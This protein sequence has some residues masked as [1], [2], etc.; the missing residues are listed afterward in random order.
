MASSLAAQLAQISANSRTSLNAK[1][2]KAAHSKSLIFEPQ[3]AAGQ[4]YAEIYTICH[5]GFEELCHLDKRFSDLFAK[6]LFSEQSQEADRTKM[7]GEENAALDKQVDFFLHQ[8]GSR[9]RLMPAIK[10]VEWLIRRFRIHEFN[11]AT[12][13]TTFLPYHTMPAFVTLLSILPPK[14]SAEYK[15]LDPYI[16]SLTAPP[17]AAI[18]QQATNS[19]ELL[20]TISQYTLASCREHQ[21]YPALIS[22]WAGVMAEV[23]NGMLDKLRSGRQAIQLENTQTL[24]Q[25]VGPT[26]GEAMVMKSIPGIQ[27]AS[28]MIVT[29]LAAKGSLDD[30]SL[31]AFMEQL[32][33]GLTTETFQPGLVTLCIIAQQRSAKQVSA[34]VAK[35]LIKVQTLVPTLLQIS[36][37]HRI[38]KL[39]NGLALAFVDRLMK[40][41]DVRSLPLIKG[42]LLANVLQEK[43][44]K[45]IY[46]ALLLAAHKIDDEVDK[47][48][49]IR[50][51][52]GSALVSLA[53][54]GGEVGD[55]V[56][57]AI[58]EVDYNIDELELNLRIGSATIRPTQVIEQGSEDEMEVK[59]IEAPNAQPNLDSALEALSKLKLT[60]SSCLSQESDSLFNDLCTVFFSAAVSETDLEKFDATPLLSRPLAP[61]NSFYFSF[62][63][64]IWCGAYPTLA[65]VAAL[66]RAKARLKD[67]DCAGKDFQA[68]AVYAAV[69]LSD[70]AKKVRRAA[71]DLLAVLNNLY[72]TP[73]PTAWGSEDLYG[74]T[75]APN[76]MGNDAAKSLVQQ[77]LVPCLEEAVLHEDHVVA[78]TVSGLEGSKS[79]T[80][81]DK[82]HISSSSRLSI[83]Q[84]ISGQVTATPLL[85]VRLRLLRSINQIKSI[86]GTSRTDLLLPLL[87]SWA[88][89]TAADAAAQVKGESLDENTVN[90][91]VVDV[92]V[93]NH[94]AGLEVLFQL[95]KDQNTRPSLV[96]AIFG[97]LVKLWPS[98][99]SNTKSET[100]EVMLALS[101][102][103][104]DSSEENT[105]AVEAVDLLRKVE[106]TT[107]ILLDFVNSLQFD[108]KLASEPPATKRRRV[109]MAEQSKAVGVPT[110]PDVRAA[111]NK[112][113]FVLELVQESMPEN[114][115]ELLP[116]LFTTLSDL[117][118]LSR[119]VG[120]EL[121]YL[122]NLVLSSLLAMIPAYKDNKELA[123]DASV[124]HG[125]VLAACIQKSTSPTVINAAL[126]LVASLARTAPDVVLQS[127]MPIFTYMG[128]SVLKQGDD[129]S[130]HVVNQ[131][132]KEVIPPLIETFRKKGRNLVASTKDLLA[133]FV[134]A[135]EHIPPHRKLDLFTSLIE[136]LG[137]DDFLFAVLA[138]FVD[139]YGAT[140][141]IISFTAEIMSHFSVEIQLS[142]LVKLIGLVG[143]VYKPKPALANTLIGNDANADQDKT[144]AKQLTLLP[145]LLANRRLKRE[146]T[147]LAERDDMESGKIRD[148]YANLLEGILN[149]AATVKGKKVLYSRCGDALSNL[150]NL[151]SI[152]E[153]IKS[154]ETLLDRPNVGLRQK[155]LRALELRVDSENTGDKQSRDAL[156]AFLPQL[157]AVIRESDDMNYKHTAVTCVDKISE[158]YGKKDLD[159][160]AAAAETI[161]GDHCLGQSSQT[162]RVMALLCLASLVDVLQDGIVPVLPVAI[163]KALSYLEDSLK[164]ETANVELHDAAYAFLAALAQH[165]PYMISGAYLDRL[166]ACS[167]TSAATELNAESNSNRLH[168]LQFLAKLVDAKTMYLALEKNWLHATNAGFSAISEYL[169]ILGMALDKHTKAVVSKN[170][171]TLSTI[172][173]NTMDLRRNMAIGECKAAL[174]D[175]EL[176]QIETMVGE[177]ALKMIYKLNDAA[178]RPVFSELTEWSFSGLP[179]ND[180]AGKTLRLLSVYGFF[181]T[182]FD[183]L[184]S[185]VTSYASYIVEMSAN[186]VSNTNLKDANEMEL[187]K[188][189]LKT[190]TKCFEHDQDGFWQAPGHFGVVAPVLIAQ[191]GHAASIEA[192]EE[193]LIPAVVEL[194][195]AADSQEHHKELN[196]TLLKH[197]RSE[198][199]A[200]RLAV[201]KCQQALTE[202]LDDEWLR[203][204]PEMLPYISELQDDDDEV[205]ERENRRWIVGI[206]GK[207]GES[208]DS[209]L[210]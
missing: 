158:K 193:V 1:A 210:Q 68:I 7:T 120:S 133:S 102:A 168:C 104:T 186:V 182:F 73:C 128:S 134:T 36:T 132:V 164:G 15:F 27:I 166:L 90:Q 58:Q 131:T 177:D 117:H 5:E 101:Q 50:N 45:V 194:A 188:R 180:V 201:V 56:R 160:V 26:L 18:V 135:Y 143:D 41:G 77:I 127:V 121:G 202:K 162:L 52:L 159:A 169:R 39:A 129:Y 189:V 49:H 60:T 92:V 76:K 114:H 63:M 46:K 106:L 20:S 130:A 28:Y 24:L 123:I 67:S 154:V 187:W 110:G 13:I 65:K 147:Q 87:Q 142:T 66:E 81:K 197:L 178:F 153:F 118:H 155:V 152:A 98:M 198:Q 161:A 42:L 139:R 84:F 8:V 173:I 33:V 16:R 125:D 3:V 64:R 105:V 23:V 40:K 119:Q 9:L 206:E 80:K 47:D 71:A 11:T 107:D 2:L 22:F 6:S 144:S 91:A 21:E 170:V 44:A 78:A 113:T 31:N 200:V 185:I 25:R 149:L 195:V 204:L 136:N 69:A 43:Q 181:H 103:A 112:T 208:L 62:Y 122:Q 146:I 72:D 174:A 79:S 179:K 175:D 93:A 108:V 190:L 115:P 19:H 196:G 75:V 209:M 89:L 96:Q 163:P 138:M 53:Q 34:K 32:V 82:K 205:V 199:A 157:T 38:D 109:S 51:E 207:L 37:Q 86:S 48:H 54:A 29:I 61:S 111:L 100:A 192:T 167:N 30:A 151:L 88:A 85:T 14:I 184:K 191:F 59:K 55:I 165:I 99:K 148:L 141:T 183:S 4:T 176:A 70:P 126:L 12:L 94:A 95:I 97:R 35:A 116:S 172:F 17:R 137:P 145:H 124:G 57:A 156:L 150:L 140:D 74:R 203:A 171:A 10:A 83:L